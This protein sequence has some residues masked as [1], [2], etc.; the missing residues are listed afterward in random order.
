MSKKKLTPNI[1]NY[2][3]TYKNFKIKVPEYYNFAIDVVDKWAKEDRNRVAMVWV[4]PNGEER[5]LTFW[6]FCVKSNKF[7][8]VLTRLDI[9]KGDKVLVILHRIPEWW[10]IVL[11][12][13]KVG[14]VFIPGTPQ[15]TSHD[16][17]YRVR[18]AEIKMVITDPENAKK[19]EEVENKLPTLEV[20][21][22]VGGEKAG[23]LSYEAE[24][25]PASRELVRVVKETPTKSTDSLLI[26]FTSG[27]TGYPKMVLHN[28]SYPLGH[29]VTA[30]FWH[31]LR[32]N[33]LHWTISDTGWA[34]TAW[35][36]LFGQWIVGSAIFVYDQRGRF[37]PAKTLELID[38]YAI[39]TF[40][41]PPTVYRML[42]L[43]D[44]DR[45]D[46]KYLRH[47]TSAGEP[48]NPEVISTWK[49]ATGLEIYEG[50]GQTE[51]TI[52]AGIF[53]S[54]KVKPGSM[55]KP[56]PGY[57]LAVIGDDL[58][59]LPPN[60]EG[61]IAVKIKPQRPVG[62]FVEYWK[63]PEA[64][65]ESF[66]GDWYITG[67]RAY[68]DE[69]GYFW[70]VGRA[71]DV[72]KSSGYRIGPFEVESALLEH[73]A[74][75][76]AAVVGSPDPIRGQIVKAFVILSPD[77][78]PSDDLVKELQEH[79]KKITAPYKYPREIEFVKEL[80]KTVSGKIRRVELRERELKKKL[81]K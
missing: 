50:Y 33:D 81:G 48:L 57:E 71:D 4:G 65:E 25:E 52:L 44:L 13:M 9:K 34:K 17:E 67:D 32:P 26:Y 51:T 29:E 31:D 53:P 68:V 74:V 75:V 58:K 15:L 76:E 43:E 64:M 28:H 5:K 66:K 6:D 16:I 79:V 55:G 70:F 2:D 46:F 35:G 41:A 3:E 54:M 12:L 30:R 24:T 11:G 40:C 47:C 37:D 59:P 42:I 36:K 18:T 56:A 72:I 7:A 8:N 14:A 63:N 77:Y 62:L 61:D 69:D 23:W 27:T 78:T 22:T 19:V 80:P 20:K 45:Y 10:E 21:M 38:E 39:T 73:P 1:G 60:Q 49:E